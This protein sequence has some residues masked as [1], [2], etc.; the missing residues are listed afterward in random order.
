MRTVE[1]LEAKLAEPSAHLVR[2]IAGLEGDLLILGVG[3]KMGPSLARL[4]KNAIRQAGLNK[5]VI[6][7]SRFSSGGLKEELE[8]DG[9]ETISADLLNE[10]ELARPSRCEECHL[11]GRNEIRYHGKRIF[12]L[13]NECL[14]ARP[15]GGE[16]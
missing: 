10:Q 5:K 8:R 14:F 11:Y 15:C 4:A 6:G 7:V 13:G 9:I 12:Q 3:G 1:E 16:V 2:D